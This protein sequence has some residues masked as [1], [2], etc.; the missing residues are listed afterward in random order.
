M[1]KLKN[2]LHIWLFE[3]DLHGNTKYRPK[4]LTLS[5]IREMKFVF[6]A[7][8]RSKKAHFVEKDLVPYLERCGIKVTQNESEIVYTAWIE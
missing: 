3:S 2:L 8:K 7:L 4:N 6:S 5:M 1:E